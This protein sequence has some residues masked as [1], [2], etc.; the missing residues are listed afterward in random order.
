MSA[1]SRTGANPRKPSNKVLGVEVE[2][3]GMI[4]CS[5]QK[6]NKPEKVAG[7]NQ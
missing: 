2:S 4:S 6:C 1:W 7:L 3:S 5:R